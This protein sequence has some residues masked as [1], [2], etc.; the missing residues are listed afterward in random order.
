MSAVGNEQVYESRRTLTT[1]MLDSVAGGD[2]GRAAKMQVVEQ[3]LILTVTE[4]ARRNGHPV[5]IPAVTWT[6]SVVGREKQESGGGTS[7]VISG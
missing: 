2:G 6:C 1:T 3:Q 7:Q 4:A 5:D